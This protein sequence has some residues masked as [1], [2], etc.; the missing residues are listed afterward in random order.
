MI[1]VVGAEEAVADGLIDPLM[2]E[3]K[4]EVKLEDLKGRKLAM[5]KLKDAM[6]EEAF[7]A[8]FLQ[9]RKELKLDLGVQIE[10]PRNPMM[11]AERELRNKRRISREWKETDIGDI[12]ADLIRAATWH[13]SYGDRGQIVIHAW[14]RPQVDE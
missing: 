13:W 2:I 3:R 4:V 11:L 14:H 10:E 8:L 12:F 6:P 7:I 1:S 9:V 5:F